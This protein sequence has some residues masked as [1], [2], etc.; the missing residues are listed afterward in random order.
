[1]PDIKNSSI[2]ERLN[3]SHVPFLDVIETNFN[4]R[5]K[6]KLND[7]LIAL[8]NT[9]HS[10]CFE[11]FMLNRDI[12]QT[13]GKTRQDVIDHLR[14][15]TSKVRLKSY[16]SIKSTVGY[17]YPNSDTIHLNEKY[18]QN[19]NACQKASQLL[20]EGAHKLGYGHDFKSTK[21]RP[22]SV[23]YSLNEAAEAC[24]YVS[25]KDIKRPK[26]R[27]CSRTWKTLWLFKTCY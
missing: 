15:S 5:Q 11:K 6:V 16:Y 1:M 2:M 19:F 27:R 21:R 22:Y 25:N 13:N 10:E 3:S 20:H 4:T 8:D 24:C 14:S 9:L 12:I 7:S 17:T 23:P 18:H 26:K